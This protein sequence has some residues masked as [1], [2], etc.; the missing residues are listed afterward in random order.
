M[1]A[2]TRSATVKD[3]QLPEIGKAGLPLEKGAGVQV[4]VL[5]ASREPLPSF[6]QW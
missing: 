1:L 6:K 5:I 3:F 4:F 2:T